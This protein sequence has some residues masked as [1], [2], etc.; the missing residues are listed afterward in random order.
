MPADGVPILNLNR[1]TVGGESSSKHS[2][3]PR[4]TDPAN[5]PHAVNMFSQMPTP[6]MGEHVQT[7]LFLPQFKST[8]MPPLFHRP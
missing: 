1:T 6:K 4:A 2:K 3:A 5:V 7:D 8:Q